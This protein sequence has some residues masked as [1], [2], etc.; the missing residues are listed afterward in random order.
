[1]LTASKGAAHLMAHGSVGEW[2]PLA[3]GKVS[4]HEPDHER[5]K[6]ESQGPEFK[7]VNVAEQAFNGASEQPAE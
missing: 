4:V 3:R 1:M 5:K 6:R 2:L 7:A